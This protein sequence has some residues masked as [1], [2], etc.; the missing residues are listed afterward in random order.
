M[1][2]QHANVFVRIED[3]RRGLWA[4]V[5]PVL[6]DLI[7]VASYIYCADQVI[8]RGSDTDADFGAKWRR[9]LHFAIP[10]RQPDLWSNLAL[11]EELEGALSFLTE[12]EYHFHFEKLEAPQPPDRYFQFGTD[13]FG[14]TVEEVLLFSGGLDSLAGAVEQAIKNQRQVALVHHRSNPKID[15]VVRR[16]VQMLV[17]RAWRKPPILL[18]VRINKARGLGQESTQR[19]RSFL[20]AALGATFAAMLGL[21]QACFYENG[22]VS[23]NLPP[24]AQVVGA[25]AS[26]TTHPAVLRSFTRLFSRLLGR[27]LEVTNP[28]LWDTKADV[29]GRIAGAGCAD[30]IGLTRSC[31][32]PRQASNDQPHCGLCSQCIDR[33]FAVL[34]AGQEA[35]DPEGTYQ[36]DLLLGE[37]PAGHAQTMLAVYAEMANHLGR[38]TPPQFFARFGEVSRVFPGVEGPPEVVAQRVFALYRKHAE[39]VTG[40]IDQALGRHISAVRER[41]LPARCLLR[42]VHCE[43]GSEPSVLPPAT[44][45][46]PSLGE[47]VFRRKGD[48][49]EVRFAGGKEF[50]LRPWVG[51]AYL[52][53]LLGQ[54]GKP[55]RAIDMAYAVAKDPARFALGTAGAALDEDALSAYRAKHQQLLEDI[56]E[57][58]KEGDTLALQELR[59]QQRSLAEQLKSYRGLGGRARKESDD[60][61]R[62]RRSVLMAIQR[63]VEKIREYD[64]RLAEHLRHPRLRCGANPCY[65]PQPEVTWDT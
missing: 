2:G 54:P 13:R 61:E 39:Q 3:L 32:R 43:G 51:A 53:M 52:H 40:V 46:P 55:M 62:V 11:R 64:R 57:E 49:W 18:P 36:V 23:L 26:R 17:D 34:A 58:E 4:D 41:S 48:V 35:H 12:D 9:Q 33:R 56:A 38:M 28:F 22:V 65:D 10:V 60:R 47:N 27:P 5:P 29:V 16:L 6:I 30:L 45:A 37:R 21:H 50:I 44:Q 25:R 14:G 8:S 63:V 15:P 24:S 42:M 59:E 19:S 31:A 20:Y 7:D 1:W